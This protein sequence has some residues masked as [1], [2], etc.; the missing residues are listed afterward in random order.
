MSGL[1]CLAYWNYLEFYILC[2]GCASGT[3]KLNCWK[4]IWYINVLTNDS[5]VSQSFGSW[6]NWMRNGDGEGE[7]HPIQSQATKNHRHTYI[8]I[9]NKCFP[10]NFNS[11][12]NIIKIGEENLTLIFWTSKN[13]QTLDF[14]NHQL[15]FYY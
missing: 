7:Q 11:N 13:F 12:E 8:Y 14:L 5:A 15:N 9:L 2:S 4:C 6:M 3:A 1:Q 10:F